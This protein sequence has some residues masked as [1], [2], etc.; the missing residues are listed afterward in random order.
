MT[1]VKEHAYGDSYDESGALF[2]YASRSGAID[3]PDNRALRAASARAPLVYFRA[4][5]PR[6]RTEIV[7]ADDPWRPVRASRTRPP[8]AGHAAR[9][10]RLRA[11]ERAYATRGATAPAPATVSSVCARTPPVRDLHPARAGARPG[12]ARGSRTASPPPSSTGLHSARSTTSARSNRNLLI[13]PRGV[14]HIAGR[15]LR[16]IDGPD[17]PRGSAG[18]S[19]R[20]LPR[21]ASHRLRFQRFSRG[22]LRWCRRV[23]IRTARR[24]RA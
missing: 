4:M 5:A 24:R 10:T 1:S 16:E 23:A 2:T 8:C 11:P 19:Q 14:V 15:L 20:Q 18:L 21:G 13:D 3:Q 17:A 9:R 12:R 6:R 7:T 22:R